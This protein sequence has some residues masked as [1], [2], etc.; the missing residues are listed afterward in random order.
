MNAAATH[1]PTHTNRA[2]SHSPPPPPRPA[3]ADRWY[4]AQGTSP[5]WSFGHGLSYST[6]TYSALSVPGT[7]TPS[8]GVTISATVCN[9]A[10][11][12]GAEVAQ[13][14]L[15][16]PAAA[17][18]PPKQ[19]KGFQKLALGPNECGGV[20]FP[21]AAA[22]LWTWDVVA[23]TWVLNPGTYTVSV[24]SSSRDIRLTGSLVVTA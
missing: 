3:P 19:L 4:D 23:Q 17:N 16:F 7:L 9:T 15:G 20:G 11:P 10:G 8:A 6:F 24:G 21:I 13:L 22:D 14:Y 1:A 5:Q 2:Q 18:A 12:A